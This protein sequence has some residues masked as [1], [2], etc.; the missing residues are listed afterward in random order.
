MKLK[1]KVVAEYDFNIDVNNSILDEVV[2]C[3]DGNFKKW[4]RN[5]YMDYFD[6][7]DMDIELDDCFYDK[8]E[9]KELLKNVKEMIGCS[10]DDLS[11]TYIDREKLRQ[12]ICVPM[13]ELKEINIDI[14]E[15]Y[16]A[17]PFVDLHNPKIELNYIHLVD[18]II[19][20]TDTR[21]LI[22][23]YNHKYNFDK[24]LLFPTYFL[25]PLK[26]GA[27]LFIN[28]DNKLYLHYEG[29][30]YQG[31]E[32]QRI[33]FPNTSK[34][35]KDDFENSDIPKIKLSDVQFKKVLI[36]ENENEAYE[37]IYD[38]RKYFIASLH[39]NPIQN[40]ELEYMGTYGNEKEKLPFFFWNKN[41]KV[42]VMPLFLDDEKI[43]EVEK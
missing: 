20:A 36:G 2:R 25:E 14:D 42:T 9:A 13:V 33:S 39:F 12:S 11:R 10:N 18:S 32:Q 22:K 21:K 1:I 4:A 3:Y 15:V 38:D 40:L 41:I 31:I 5:N 43:V 24:E 17:L 35:I 30:Y 27:K 6:S 34:I 37:I 7:D 16:K 23:I 26:N 8:S 28:E 29:S 19:E